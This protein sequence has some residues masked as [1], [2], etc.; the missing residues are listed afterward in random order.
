MALYLFKPVVW[1]EHGYRQPGGGTFTSGYPAVHG[2]GH[3]EWNNSSHF[4]F[5]EHGQRLRI[6]HTEGVRNQPLSQHSGSIFLFL[7]AS[8]NGKQYLVGIAGQAT[9]L[10]EK[11]EQERQRLSNKLGLHRLWREAWRLPSVQQAHHQSE[12]E[13]RRHWQENYQWLP[14]WVCPAD[15]Y[16]PLERPLELDPERLTGRKRLITMYSSYQKIDRSVALRVFDLIPTSENAEVLSKLKTLCGSDLRDTIDDIGE[17][18]AEVPRETT[19]KALI[20]ARLGQ[21]KFRDDLKLRWDDCCAVTGCAVIEILRASHVKPWAKSSKLEKLDQEN[22][23]L[24]R[25]DLDALFDAGLISFDD[26]GSMLM[27]VHL[28]QREQEKLHLGGRLRKMPSAKL[29]QYLG[30]HR[31]YRLR[32]P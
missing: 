12:G 8:H 17:I 19:R 13:F 27:S 26:S 25:A 31:R 7:S 4:E 21:G 22:G 24:L 23:L 5:S 11:Q 18:E 16:L 1:N 29:K 15:S 10:F 6:F 14:T 30:Y 3:E 32:S 20:D 2:F 28:A 9:G